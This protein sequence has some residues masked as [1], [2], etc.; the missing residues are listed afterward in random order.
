MAAT[1]RIRFIEEIFSRTGVSLR[2]DVLVV[3]G[4]YLDFADP[5]AIGETRDR[6]IVCDAHSAQQ[7]VAKAALAAWH[8]NVRHAYPQKFVPLSPYQRD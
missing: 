5:S 8:D 2:L 1:L 3:N 4:V 7:M 6:V